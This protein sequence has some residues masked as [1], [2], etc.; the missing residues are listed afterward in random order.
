MHVDNIT[1]YTCRVKEVKTVEI[2]ARGGWNPMMKQILQLLPIKTVLELY[3][4]IS[5]AS[6]AV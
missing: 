6:M 4:E 2:I 1:K 5:D 3:N